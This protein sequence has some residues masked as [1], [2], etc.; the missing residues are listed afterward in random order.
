MKE[1]PSHS[2]G[3]SPR[4]KKGRHAVPLDSLAAPFL[5][6]TPDFR[7]YFDKPEAL[8]QSPEKSP[9]DSPQG[10]AD[11]NKLPENLIDIYRDIKGKYRNY[12]TRASLRLIQAFRRT[13]SK[14][15]QEKNEHIALELLG[16]LNFGI[17]ESSSDADIILIHYC[18]QHSQEAECPKGCSKTLENR[19][20]IETQVSKYLGVS[21]FKLEV[22]DCINL[23]SIAS[24]LRQDSQIQETRDKYVETCLRFLF[25]CDLG[26]PVNRTLFFPYYK[27]LKED[28]S[29]QAIFPKWSS[30]MLSYYLH[31]SS[32][33]LSFYKY[34]QRILSQGLVIPKELQI[35]LE[36]YLKQQ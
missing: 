8:Q 10:N 30:E 32:H 24:Y 1:G 17:V 11:L 29:M 27:L 25:Y 21:H 13:L 34:N 14:L 36:H 19:S 7:S 2:H 23:Y 33:R 26:R 31:T 5:E 18:K 9:P 35:E 3:H 15:S 6:S 22:L 28:P 16:S 4:N 20:I 12:D